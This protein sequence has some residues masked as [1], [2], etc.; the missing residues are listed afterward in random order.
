MLRDLD[1]NASF[2]FEGVIELSTTLASGDYHIVVEVD[3][4]DIVE[5]NPPDGEL[6]KTT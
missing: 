2:I 5:E 4:T 6:N 1:P 3:A